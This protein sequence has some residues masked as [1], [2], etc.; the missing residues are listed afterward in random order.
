MII[1][2]YDGTQVLQ[3]SAPYKLIGA[4]SNNAQ[5][6]K[7][8]AGKINCI[9]AINIGATVRYLKFYN[10]ATTPAPASDT[11]VLVIPIPANTAGAGVVIPFPKPI[12]FGTGIGIAIVNGISDTDNTNITANEVVVNLGYE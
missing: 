6:V 4:A 3:H 1:L 8:S 5:V 11:P 9:A 12:L 7:A 10:K 2:D